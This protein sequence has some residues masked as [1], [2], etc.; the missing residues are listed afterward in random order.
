LNVLFFPYLWG[1]MSLLSAAH[2]VPSVTNLGG[3][4]GDPARPFSQEKWKL[5][6]PNG[7]GSIAEPSFALVHRELFRD[8]VLPLWNPDAGFG[9]PLAAE[10]QQQPF[11][12]LNA[13]VALRPGPTIFA[14]YIL[15][16]LFVAGFATYLFVRC[17]VGFA[18]A[19]AAAI[20]FMLSGYFIHYLTM[21][22]LSVE[23]L[24]PALFL[25]VEWIVRDR[26]RALAVPFLGVVTTCDLLGGMPESSFLNV[27]FAGTYALV[28]VATTA[29][30]RV[31]ARATLQRAAFA[32]GCGF[33][34]AGIL[35]VPFAEFLSHSFNIHEVA[36]NGGAISGSIA[37]S[38]FRTSFPLYLMP[39]VFGPPWEA[40]QAAGIF[41]ND[42]YFGIAVAFLAIAALTYLVAGRERPH[43]APIVFFAAAALVLV[44]KRYGC[45]AVNWIGYLPVV[46][47]ITLVKYEECETAFALA[48]LAGFG[49][50][51]ILARRSRA[52]AGALA[53]S[54]ATLFL[55]QQA[56]DGSVL[57]VSSAVR[58]ANLY[59][60]L[61][62]LGALGAFAATAAFA[63]I[64]A[65][66]PRIPVRVLATATLAILTLELS[67]NYVVPM[68]YIVD[69]GPP[70]AQNPYLG[71]PYV[72]YLHDRTSGAGRIYGEKT[73]ELLPNWAGAFDL[74]DVRD[75][76]AL[77]VERYLPLA[78]S[79]L[80]K[81]VPNVLV[82]DFSGNSS[83]TAGDAIGQRLLTLGSVRYVVADAIADPATPFGAIARSIAHDSSVPPPTLGSCAA[84]NV[85]RLC[86][87]LPLPGGEARVPYAV[88]KDARSLAVDLA[89]GG[90]GS[91]SRDASA[92][93][94]LAAVDA[95]GVRHV[96]LTMRLAA[97][98]AAWRSAKVDV[99]A[100]AGSDIVL[101]FAG[102][103]NGDLQGAHVSWSRLAVNEQRPA[104]ELQHLADADVFAFDR[105]LP[106]GAVYGNV[107]VAESDG[108][109]L[110][111]LD[112][113]TF[114]LFS[115]VV[116][117][118]DSVPHPYAPAVA[119]LALARPTRVRAARL[120]RYTP[121][122]VRFATD[123]DG[124]GLFFLSDTFYPGWKATV[125]G[126]PAPIVRADYLFRG[127]L[128]EP[129]KHVVALRYD[130]LSFKFGL[131][132]T[133]LGLGALAVFALRAHARGT[134]TTTAVE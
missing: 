120:L 21:P 47:V 16:R 130:P 85:W 98:A 3:P 88:P 7:S 84:R 115:H 127:V 50:D 111:A 123:S 23:T 107:D 125:D 104:F 78:R 18:P 60:N 30:L 61:A 76:D 117:S 112:D 56:S 8:R 105:P 81:D 45:P 86:L 31:R 132:L 82:S 37:D 101:L 32:I 75:I 64:A 68:Y 1:N 44:A 109:A 70:K 62:V 79:F 53:A 114:D 2:D 72:R 91:R 11:F 24:T 89:L 102:R 122:D 96:L 134:G 14:L 15:L 19:L 10:M 38:S 43:A 118:A 124:P 119:G 92:V 41:F 113:P 110:A 55:L 12:P 126:V 6:D 133:L 5:L 131:V 22:H 58:H 13:L 9:K 87:L 51:A 39:L 95:R 71:A 116:V 49:L 97:S 20:A 100:Y 108:E 106:Y 66:V 93:A 83:Y 59:Y 73:G 65:R 121:T 26:R 57:A 17:F 28:R 77:Y 69:P 54:I 27:T 128:L 25:G 48:V 90:D 99:R 94:Q 80:A 103:A 34:G 52:G 4:G 40:G 35:L 63:V 129:G 33:L 29:N 36:K 74:E 67:F 46:R 42:G